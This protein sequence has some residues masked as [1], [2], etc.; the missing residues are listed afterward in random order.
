VD[1]C[2]RQDG[3]QDRRPAT[4]E[5]R[6]EKDRYD[7]EKQIAT[8]AQPWFEGK[9]NECGNA[10]GND[11]QNIASPGPVDSEKKPP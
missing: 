1:G 2:H 7:E 3:C 4:G 6:C 9:S 11:G 8:T 10:D 5:H